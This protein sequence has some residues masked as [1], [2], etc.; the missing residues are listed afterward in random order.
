MNYQLNWPLSRWRKQCENLNE[1]PPTADGIDKIEA[2]GCY[3]LYCSSKIRNASRLVTPNS[4]HAAA[5]SFLTT[6][7]L[8]L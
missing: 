8:T 3:H 4:L 7:T 2:E 1:L 6:E 5:M